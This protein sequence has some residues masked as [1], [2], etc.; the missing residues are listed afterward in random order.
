M[1]NDNY[2][3]KQT[4]KPL[5]PDI[6]WNKPERKSTAGKLLI[7]GGNLHLILATSEA[8][9]SAEKAGI[10]SIKLLL[11]DSTKRTVGKLIENIE[12]APSTPSGSFSKKALPELLELA[13][14]SDGVLLA[15]DFGHNSETSILFNRFLEEYSGI[16]T[17]SQDAVDSFITYPKQL[18]ERRNSLLVL[19]FHK[20]QKLAVSSNF[21]KPFISN[22]NLNN[23]IEA[24]HDFSNSIAGTYIITK[25][26]NQIH[27]AVN[28]EITSTKDVSGSLSMIKISAQAC[29]W[30][31]QNPSTPLG[32]ITSSIIGN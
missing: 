9:A 20:L 11:P 1:V 16:L 13:N 10:G 24:L 8:F 23:F 29:V 25:H 7:V 4:E 19:D 31:L 28:G 26:L 6:I 30:W 12:F 2:W 14:W 17:I 32:A 3:L 5:F 21:D 27:C 18:L 22:M 15:G